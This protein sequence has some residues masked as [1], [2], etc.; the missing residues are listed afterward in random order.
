MKQ[1]IIAFFAFALFCAVAV[2]QVSNPIVWL[3]AD[4]TETAT[5]VWRDISGNGY[6]AVFVSD[7][8]P[9][10]FSRMNFNKSVELPGNGFFRIPLDGITNRMSDVIIVYETSDTSV[11]N[12]LWQLALDSD[13][14]VGQTTQRILNDNGQI[15]YDSL[16]RLRPVI[17]YLSQSW[18]E[19]TGIARILSAGAVDTLYLHG[20]F[21]ELLFFDRNISDTSVIQWMSCL[22]I[23]YG[24]TLSGTDYFDSHGTRI[25]SRDDAPAFSSSISGIGR[26]DLTGLYQK[27]SFFADGNII[28][29]IGN[30][31]QNNE[32]NLSEIED[33]DF[34]LMGMDSDGLSQFSEIYLNDQN[35]CEVFGQSMVQ[36]SGNVSSYSTFLFLEPLSAEDTVPPVLLI[37]RSGEGNYT[38]NET[39]VVRAASIDSIGRFLYE[40]VHWDTDG[41]GRDMFCFAARLPEN[42]L[43]GTESVQYGEQDEVSQSQLQSGNHN[44][45]RGGKRLSQ[46][47]G[48]ESFRYSVT[49]NPNHGKF[50]V[51]LELA[52]IQDITVAIYTSDGKKLQVMKG[53]GQSSYRFEGTIGHAG[54]Y[55]VEI[56]TPTEHRTLKMIVN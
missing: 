47:A 56:V 6:D 20:R 1:K 7:S 38:M 48:T 26:D 28:Y 36:T 50:I 32:D 19:E 22:A 39:A 2:A 46:G 3:R 4:S 37:D 18:S 8:V 12:G 13:R 25:W 54:H 34:I 42:L 43:Q 33:G 24:V 51:E 55:L 16:N 31:A 52:E 14:R 15:R 35:S 49:P 29:G 10:T 9:V 5:P 44:L 11:E 41:N 17:N 53:D 21:S 45:D 23:R 40:G 30:L 27:Q